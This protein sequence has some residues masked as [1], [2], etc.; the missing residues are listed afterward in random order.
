MKWIYLATDGE[1]IHP[2]LAI[3]SVPSDP[4][5][6]IMCLIF[7]FCPHAFVHFQIVTLQRPSEMPDDVDCG[8]VGEVSEFLDYRPADAPVQ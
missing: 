6:S 1:P 8:F 2:L 4:I 5:L 3:F 7:F